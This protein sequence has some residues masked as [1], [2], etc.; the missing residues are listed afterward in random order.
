[1]S[2]TSATPMPLPRRL[3][4]L[5]LYAVLC[6]CASACTRPNPDF[7]CTSES[8]CAALGV[9]EVRTCSGGRVCDSN[10]CLAVQCETGA[11]CD[12]EAPYCANQVCKATCAGDDD[13]VDAP[14][15]PM[16]AEDGVCVGCMSDDD[17]GEDAPI[18]SPT[19][20]VCS[21][22]RADADC[23]SGVCLAAD[24]VCAKEGALI[25][26]KDGGTDDGN[27]L[28]SAPCYT[29]SHA[30]QLVTPVRRVIRLLGPTYVAPGGIGVFSYEVH[31]DAENTEI[32]RTTEGPI[33][34][35]S[36]T[37]DMTLE[38]VKFNV[39]GRRAIGV[40]RTGTVRLSQI[41]GTGTGSE[42]LVLAEA[43]TT[44]IWDSKLINGVTLC[45]RAKIIVE[46]SEFQNGAVS[47]GGS[48]VGELR[49]NIFNDT[50]LTVEGGLIFQNNLVKVTSPTCDHPF[51]G[52][53]VN[54]IDFNTWVCRHTPP[55]L[56]PSM[57]TALRCRPEDRFTGNL[58][59]WDSLIPAKDC[60]LRHSLLPSFATATP[61]ENNQYVDMADVFIDY[62]GGD[63]HL[64]RSSPAK[65][66]GDPRSTLA[67]DLEG[68][69]RP[70]PK[71][72][73]PDIGAFEAP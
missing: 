7:C 54:Q 3:A 29:F 14:L 24:G 46:N 59:A 73:A 16:C 11:Q 15:G 18:C 49:R 2:V 61:G 26:V 17:C 60:T 55:V 4:L 66:A 22:C 43:G 65:A 9:G 31:I 28:K 27:C 36:G 32:R 52:G 12:S 41:Q 57:G 23:A 63:Y 58:F 51:Q 38:G 40:T 1:M 37:G 42:N 20:R 5:F 62:L 21:P 8:E 70:N 6:T 67:V 48:C 47:G 44:R 19:K 33:V 71:G 39:V 25:Y 50:S 72:S 64:S 34:D 45:G 56:D 69:P 35:I 13:C 53:P 30:L 10:V 68:N